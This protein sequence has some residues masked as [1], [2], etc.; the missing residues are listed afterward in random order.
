MI[1]LILVILILAT[2]EVGMTVRD[3]VRGWREMK[4]LG[5]SLRGIAR[6]CNW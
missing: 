2:A 1:V 6:Q 5:I 4:R 3:W